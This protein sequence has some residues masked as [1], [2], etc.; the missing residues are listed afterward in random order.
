MG[1]GS[2]GLLT[3][4]LSGL[5]PTTARAESP[6]VNILDVTRDR[7]DSAGQ[8]PTSQINLNDCLTDDTVGF[9]LELAEYQA[10]AL[11]IW[12][13]VA[14]DTLTA[15]YPPTATCWRISSEAPHS[16]ITTVHVSVR[17]L[18]RGRTSGELGEGGTSSTVPECTPASTVTAA[19]ILDTYVMLLDAG[20]SVGASSIWRASFK[21][22]PAPPPQVIAVE[23]GEGQLSVHL[24]PPTLANEEVS[25]VELY[26]DPG[27]SDPNAA[28]NAQI[29]AGGVGA[30]TPMCSPSTEL[31]PGADA[32]SLQHLRCGSAPRTT[33][34]TVAD[35]LVNG[36]SY[37]I[38]AASVDTYGNI[39]PLSEVA[40][41]VP[42]AEV[43]RAR[44]SE[45]RARACAFV[46][47]DRDRSGIGWTYLGAVGTTLLLR[48]LH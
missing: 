34:T 10:Y 7:Q 1:K 6:K 26:C 16:A 47:A 21:L 39:G 40:C 18:L 22:K 13:G 38:A 20:G 25:R 15:R 5:L 24:A 12:A 36:V 29:A 8:V 17:D 28:A 27:P 46:L 9:V 3:V 33:A 45:E 42:Q 35:G 2:F 14:C 30:F 32:T 48:R 37:N 11:E 41:E 44:E 43:P 4:L 31:V 19:Q 23:S